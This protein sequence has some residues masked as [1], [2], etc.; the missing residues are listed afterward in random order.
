MNIL[1]SKEVLYH[2]LCT[3]C[4]RWWSIAD[5]KQTRVLHCPHC[6]LLQDVIKREN[7]TPW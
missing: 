1:Y 2:L 5:W 6:G 3:N 4:N 7:E